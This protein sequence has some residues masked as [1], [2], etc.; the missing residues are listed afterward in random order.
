[1][2]AKYY[3]IDGYHGGKY[4]HMPPGAF[5]DILECLKRHPD[6]K[7]SLD[8]EPESWAELQRRD[9]RVYAQ[10]CELLKD[11][12]IH[13]RL[14]IVAGTYA[15]PYAWLTDG[16]S[17]IRHLK[18]GLA[19]I[20]RHFPWIR[21]TTYAVQEPCWTSAMPQILRSFGF[22]R[23][24]LKNPSTAWAGYCAGYDAQTVLWVGPDGTS[25]PTVPRYACEALVNT[26]QTESCLPGEQ[27]L[28][29]CAARGI[30]QPAGMWFQDL[31]WPAYPYLSS[32]FLHTC[33]PCENV[34][35]TTWKEYMKTCA[36]AP[37]AV[38]RI[39]QEDFRVTL[40]WGDQQLSHMARM[41]R[42]AE[43]ALL[44]AHMLHALRCAHA[45]AA[46]TPPE[47]TS[48]SRRIMLAQ[49]HDGW[50]C[51]SCGEG[52]HNWAWQCCARVTQAMQDIERS[53]ADALRALCPPCQADA[54]RETV[55]LYST[56]AR[57]EKRIARIPLSSGM[58]VRGWRALQNGRELPCQFLCERA[59]ADGSANAGTLLV[60]L[61]TKGAGAAAIC[62]EATNTA[63]AE[64]PAATAVVRGNTAIL[65][66][67]LYRIV[68]DLEKGGR[69]ISLRS[70]DQEFADADACQP[71]N[72]F[73]G[74]FIGEKRFCCSAEHPATCE[75]THTGALEAQVRLKGRVGSAYFTQTVT[76]QAGERA[77]AVDVEFFFPEE[78]HIGEDF[79]PE[80]GEENTQRHRSY[81]DGRYKLNAW[82]P[83]PFAQ[84]ALYKD[85]AFDVC[86]SR[87][88]DTHFTR[89][90]DIHHNI[91]LHFVDVYG[92]ACGLAVFSD[93][94]AAYVHGGDCPLGLT[95][96][97]G[98]DGGYWWRN[99]F[100]K[101]RHSLSYS[102]LP[103][104][105]DWR[106]AD[107]WHEGQK[108]RFPLISQRLGGHCAAEPPLLA[109]IES[110]AVELSCTD[111]DEEGRILLR[112]FNPGT[113]ETVSLLLP[114]ALD[115]L[116][117][118]CT[119]DGR[120][121]ETLRADAACGG[122]RLTLS[123][124]P[125]GLCTVRITRSGS[126]VEIALPHASP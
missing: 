90:D 3:A 8:I 7:L 40:P 106:A 22:E 50:I 65:E 84:R 99:R 80:D 32:T 19:T 2:P 96:A 122:L 75:I 120:S 110:P 108:L 73:T 119:L 35:Y 13:A 91:L 49:H 114:R 66:S 116:F 113:V 45:A 61:D 30:Q 92:G 15:Q 60:Q 112:L 104:R 70:Q 63:P 48:A 23:A 38:W 24:V 55:W 62:V 74:Y 94:T 20:A 105:G 31:G 83:T 95:L 103:H 21:V 5:Q 4:G 44:S 85:A 28:E 87:N 16:E 82:F 79:A 97:W 10:F 59:Y 11:T 46:P 123:L 51:A 42:T 100:L 14:E 115:G 29:K 41:V 36:N 27:F 39:T 118:L 67:D 72:G 124:P 117:E 126:A 71:F 26:W 77:I 93:Q 88:A 89:W 33:F 56:L 6:W 76:V 9:P 98:H 81:H 37:V 78:T 69:I 47:L 18:Y 101:G 58:G 107:L 102:I 12:S 64:I 25:I 54:A 53:N 17:I 1:M 86:Q 68:F 43:N 52:E 34:Q 121:L 111:V 57:A 109:Q 125:F